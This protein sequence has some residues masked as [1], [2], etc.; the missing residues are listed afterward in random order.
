MTETTH[1]RICP[2]CE[3][4]CGLEIKTQGDKVISIRGHDADVFS[5]GYICPK[6]VALKDLHEDPDRLRTPLIKRNGVFEEATWDEA[7]AE[8]ERRL[9][10]IIAAHGRNATGVVV[11]NPSAHK[12]GLLTYFGKLARALGTK[13]VFSASTLDQMP[14]QLASG[15]MFGHWLSVALPDIARTD[16]L[17]VLGA[18]PLASNGSMWT[19]PDFKGKAKALQARGGQLV[20]IDPRRTETAAMADAH[21]FIRPGADVFLLAAMV[22]TL[23]AEKLVRLGPVA[24][25]VVGIDE[26]GAAV[27]PFTPETVAARC[28]ISADTI[29]NLART[30]ATTPRAAVY[31]RIG[32]CTQQYGTLASWLIDVLNTLSGHLDLPG[33]V[34]FA[35]SAAFASNTAGKA[36]VGK[37]VST[38][39]HHARVSGAPEVYGELPMTCL[40]EEIETPGE[41]QLRALFTVATNPVLSSPDGPRVAKALDALEFMVSM[42]IYLNET[43]RHADVILPGR[44]PL[45]ELHYDV[46]FPQLSWRNHARYSPPVFPAP[47]GQPEEWQTILKLAAI[48]QGKGAAADAN[49][50][51][52]AQFAEDAQRLFGAHADAVLAATAHYKGPQRGLDVA[53]RSGPYGDQFGRKPDGLTLARVMASNASGGIDLGA[54]QPRIPEILRTPSGKVELAAPLLLQDLERAAQDLRGLAPDLVIIG[55]RDVRTNN[56]WMHNLPVLAKG[57]FRCTALV[58]PHDAARLGLTDGAL[59]S[60]HNGPRSVQAQVHISDEMMPGV[61]SLPHGW[62]HNLPGAKLRVAAE[63]PGANLNALLDDQLRDPLSGNAVLGGV[64]VTMRAVTTQG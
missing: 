55:R 37:G 3:A 61:V 63:R 18:N 29:R 30:L 46:A 23:F 52:D 32:T 8:I 41:G 27:A 31:G 54:L 19:V 64:A 14:K 35:K 57:P 45:E 4:C 21:H 36:G 28:G 10:P 40:A 47:D 33:G 17:L 1:H 13:N 44:S 42:D 34:L 39:R 7:F 38:G 9:L 15:L 20:V 12:I 11:G 24:E 2:L 58:H 49:T 25:W 5:A 48:V 43:T 22:Q 59:A 56:S 16:Y 6:G 50:L 51:D 60:I 26:V 53:L 62:G